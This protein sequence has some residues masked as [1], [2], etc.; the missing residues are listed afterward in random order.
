MPQ[1]SYSTKKSSYGGA[2]ST[3]VSNLKKGFVLVGGNDRVG[4]GMIYIAPF[5]L[6]FPKKCHLI[7]RFTLPFDLKS[8]SSSVG[9]HMFVDRLGN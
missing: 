7:V 3:T 4:Q 1:G 2:N 5:P 9:S 6:S 8:H